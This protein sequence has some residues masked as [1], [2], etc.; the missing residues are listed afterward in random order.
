M[1]GDLLP[2]TGDGLRGTKVPSL[3]RL[4]QTGEGSN[5]R[6]GLISWGCSNGGELGVAGGFGAEV[7]EAFGAGEE[8]AGTGGEARDG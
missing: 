3:N 1:N 7:A 2:L 5:D 4:R 8:A 6:R